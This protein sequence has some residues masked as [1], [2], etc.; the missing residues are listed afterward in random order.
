VW[1]P[2]DP[3]DTV[4]KKVTV[5]VTGNTPLKDVEAIVS[6]YSPG[7]KYTGRWS[8]A[9]P[10]ATVTDSTNTVPHGVIASAPPAG[11]GFSKIS[12]TGGTVTGVEVTDKSG[13]EITGSFDQA[14]GVWTPDD[15]ADTRGEKV[16]VKVQG[17]TVLE[18]VEAVFTTSVS[19]DYTGRW[20]PAEPDATITD[21]TNTV[22]NGK[23]T[24]AAPEGKGFSKISF[25]GGKV[26]GVEVTDGNA[27]AASSSTAWDFTGRWSPADP[28]ATITDSTNTHEWR[29]HHPH[30]IIVS[31]APAG[32]GFSKISFNGGKLTGVTVHDHDNN[33]FTGTLDPD[34]GVW[35]PDYPAD[36]VGTKVAVKVTGNAVLEDV[37]AVFTS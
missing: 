28:D 24:N 26:T 16:T 37:G 18:D 3:A 27:P 13:N 17:N 32:K 34:T 35:I 8:P 15:P 29:H 36:T 14:T 30:A 31:Q 7:W 5:K 10:D 21:S 11:K 12:F 9:E 6:P 1:T 22:T 25:N 2:N 20:S 4:G 23:I 19:W 33:E